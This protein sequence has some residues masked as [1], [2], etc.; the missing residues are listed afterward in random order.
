LDEDNTIKEKLLIIRELQTTSKGTDL[1]KIISDYF[2]K[3]DILWEKLAGFCTDGAP[4]MLGSRSGLATLVKAKNC[5][6]VTTHCMIHRQA[7]ASKTLPKS[8]RTP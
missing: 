3:H 8:W 7:L 6:T 4:A 2:Q 5:R 1:M